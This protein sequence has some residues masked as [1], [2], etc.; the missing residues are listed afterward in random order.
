MCWCELHG[1]R[2]A[3]IDN[4]IKV[5]AAAQCVGFAYQAVVMQHDAVLMARVEFTGNQL[6]FKFF[7][8]QRER[9]IELEDMRIVEFT[10]NTGAVGKVVQAVALLDQAC[11]KQRGDGPTQTP[12]GRSDIMPC[13]RF[14]GGI[15]VSD[16]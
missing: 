12:P 11:A 8:H 14:G 7:E 5:A 15:P 4:Q 3:G 16:M 1:W 9:L 2:L 6:E 10:C 13:Y